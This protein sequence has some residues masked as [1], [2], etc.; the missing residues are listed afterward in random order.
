[1]LRI[2]FV[3]KLCAY[4]LA[5]LTPGI[6]PSKAIDRKQILHT[7]NLRRY[8]RGRPQILHRLYFLVV[9]FGT[10]FDFTTRA[11]RATFHLMVLNYAAS[12]C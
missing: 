1:M 4:Q 3:T 8:A 2:S 10:L 9:N 12:V 7:P 5:F 11:F 6:F